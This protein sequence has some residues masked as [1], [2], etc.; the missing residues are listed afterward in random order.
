M[1]KIYLFLTL[2]ARMMEEFPTSKVHLYN[3]QPDLLGSFPADVC[4]DFT[5]QVGCGH[6]AKFSPSVGAGWGRVKR[7]LTNS[8]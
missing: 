1:G 2:L 3:L 5:G 6:R 4:P 8:T 7:F